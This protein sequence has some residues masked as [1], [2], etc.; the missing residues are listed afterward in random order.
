MIDTIEIEGVAPRAV[1]DQL[2]MAMLEHDG[3]E[4]AVVKMKQWRFHG[5]CKK[6]QTINQE[7]KFLEIRFNNEGEVPPEFENCLIIRTHLSQFKTFN[8]FLNWAERFRPQE[9][10][11]W[12]FNNF[13][14]KRMDL[15][16]DIP[17]RC[18]TVAKSL[19]RP[20]VRIVERFKGKQKS[21]KF[22][23]RNRD[24]EYAFPPEDIRPGFTYYWGCRPEVMLCY[25]RELE[26]LDVDGRVKRI[27]GC[28]IEMRYTKPSK[29]PVKNFFD[30]EAYLNFNPYSKITTNEMKLTQLYPA[31]PA[32]QRLINGFI[33]R[34][35]EIGFSQARKEYSVDSTY[36]KKIGPYFGTVE[37]IDLKGMYDQSIL[38]FFGDTPFIPIHCDSVRIENPDKDDSAWRP[39]MMGA[40][41][42]YSFP[43]QNL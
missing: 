16:I 30:V 14:I 11:I 43:G 18:E 7:G 10:W 38:N 3:D 1:I 35:D 41:E 13:K 2:Q 27:L 34:V 25:E 26:I 12:L 42:G 4:G 40:D 33:A 8:N 6:V 32:I 36:I 17:F 39:L 29:V 9:N 5:N 31:K 19:H 22:S 37:S 15:A 23:K 24:H 20:G 21:K 28:R